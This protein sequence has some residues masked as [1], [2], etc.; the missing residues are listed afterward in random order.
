MTPALGW[1][2]GQS[3]CA[4]VKCQIGQNHNLV[5]LFPQM[6]ILKSLSCIVSEIWPGQ[7][8]QGEGH[9]AKVKGR[10]KHKLAQLVR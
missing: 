2:S 9:C 10:K 8:L 1:F 3:Y 5:Q 7:D 6:I 4:K